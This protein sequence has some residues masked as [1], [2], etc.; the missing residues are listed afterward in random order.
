MKFE[1]RPEVKQHYNGQKCLRMAR[2]F[3]DR[4]S[5]AGIPDAYQR[6]NKE[7]FRSYLFSDYHKGDSADR[8]TDLIYDTPEALFKIPF[9]LIDG[10]DPIGRKKAGYAILF[11]LILFDKIARSIFCK[12]LASRL[13]TYTSDRDDTL[14]RI[15]LVADLALYDAVFVEEFYPSIFN[16]N[17][18]GGGLMDSLIDERVRRTRPTIISFAGAI[19]PITEAGCGR[20]MADLLNKEYPN[21][22]DHSIN[23]SADIL[24]VRIKKS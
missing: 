1:D 12:D 13:E 20:Y 19:S 23:P 21:S 6:I 18:D 24:R 8:I 5:E 11:R 2:I 15:D 3:M 16:I 22:Q 10:G 7:T 9:I 14:V 17:R 4:A